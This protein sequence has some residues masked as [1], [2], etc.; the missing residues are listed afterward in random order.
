MI[1]IM[2]SFI[3]QAMTKLDKL[4]AK[5]K[6]GN[7]DAVELRALL[8]KLGW[9]LERTRGSHEIWV[10]GPETFVIATHAKD[11]KPYQKKQARDVLL[12]EEPENGSK[13]N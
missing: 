13:E 9:R 11:L 10:Q 12:K 5:L 7:I 1:S 6:N 3:L 2:I 4:I 8:G